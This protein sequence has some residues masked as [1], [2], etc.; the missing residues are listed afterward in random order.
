MEE[1]YEEVDYQLCLKRF[2]AAAVSQRA[3]LKKLK[4][5]IR[6]KLI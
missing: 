2:Q 5:V 1:K 4:E 3:W 6:N